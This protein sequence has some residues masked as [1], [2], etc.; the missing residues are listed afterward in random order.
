MRRGER[1]FGR[2]LHLRIWAA[3]LAGLLA[4]AL[5]AGLAWRLGAGEERPREIRLTG[6]DGR[7]AGRATLEFRAQPG[8]VRV[9][10]DD[11]RVL[12]AHW[13]EAG[14]RP[15]VSFLLWLVLIVA[16]VGLATYPVARRLTRRLEQLQQAVD[17][18]GEGDLQARVMVRGHDEVALLA[19]R[20]NRAAERIEALVSA[21]KNLL[22]NASHELR[23]PLARIRMGLEMIGR[24]EDATAR[25]AVARDIADLDGLIEEILLA[26][27]LDSSQA[28]PEPFEDVDLTALAAEECSRAAAE[29]QAQEVVVTRGSQRL[30]RRALRNLLDNALRHA[31]GTPEVSV[32]RDAE[33]AVLTVAD[34]GP[35][36]PAQLRERVFEPF[37]RLPGHGDT[38]RPGGLGL[39]LVRAIANAHGGRVRCE[40]RAGGGALFRLDLPLRG[41]APAGGK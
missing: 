37:Y 28:P 17:A 19:A 30:L 5:L 9:E 31:A 14:N 29:L 6:T 12:I 20:F 23:S 2:H 1:R 3:L 10:L 41:P 4:T 8:T 15:A 11:G 18:L 7:D 38:E 24:G 26:S 32:Y 36:I 33:T 16:A 34:R 40:E 25:A 35:G 27:R 22:A 39:S 21:H 13:R